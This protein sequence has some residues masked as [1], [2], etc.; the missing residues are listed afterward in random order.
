[1]VLVLLFGLMA[2]SP[3]PQI[4]ELADPSV[5][6]L[7]AQSPDHFEETVW[8]AMELAQE[9]EAIRFDVSGSLAIIDAYNRANS[10]R[11]TPERWPAEI[12]RDRSNFRKHFLEDSPNLTL[13]EAAQ[14]ELESRTALS[15]LWVRG[16]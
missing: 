5:T 4:R 13:C 1:M 14:Q 8:L 15:A 3:E 11:E 9:C 12:A 6:N 7:M 2:C 16:L 10:R